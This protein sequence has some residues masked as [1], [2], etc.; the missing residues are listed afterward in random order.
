MKPFHS[1]LLASLLLTVSWGSANAT[2]S[3]VVFADSETVLIDAGG[4][5]VGVD[6]GGEE[7]DAFADSFG[8]V[9]PLSAAAFNESGLGTLEA[10]GAASALGPGLSFAT[11]TAMSGDRIRL[12][13]PSTSE[14]RTAH[15][16]FTHS[17]GGSA[18]VDAGGS[19][20]GIVPFF[21]ITGINDA[22]GLE[23]LDI[24]LGGGRIDAPGD[25]YLVDLTTIQFGPGSTK[26]GPGGEET[27]IDFWVT[28]GPGEEHAFSVITDAFGAAFVVPVPGGA[29]LLLAGL[30][31]LRRRH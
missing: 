11:T 1:A 5:E 4:L 7:A 2:A 12:F 25:E 6:V 16:T 15:F 31:L 30:P 26:V 27:T 14:V 22:G 9:G 23:T 18:T 21:H 24:D 8:L 10:S 13:N 3:Y 17:A 20:A 29:L 28:I 19:V